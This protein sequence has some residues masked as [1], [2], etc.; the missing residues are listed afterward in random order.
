MLERNPASGGVNIVPIDDPVK[1]AQQ[2]HPEA[3]YRITREAG[4]FVV[5][6]RTTKAP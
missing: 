6:E 5:M 4:P 3:R 1:Y 2:L